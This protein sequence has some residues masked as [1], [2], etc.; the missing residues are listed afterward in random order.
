MSHPGSLNGRTAAFGI[1]L[2][3]TASLIVPIVDG[4]AKLLGESF[5]PLMVAW[6]RYAMAALIVLPIACVTSPKSLLPQTQR[7][8]H[9]MRTLCLVVAMTLFFVSLQWTPLATAI[10]AYFSGPVIA[11]LLS[12]LVLKERINRVKIASLILA[13]VGALIILR[14]LDGGSLGT[15]LAFL[16]GA[17]HAI[18]LIV[19]KVAS[20]QSDSLQTLS[21]QCLVGT[22]ILTPQ[23]V[24]TFTLP[25][26]NLWWLFI[27]MGAISALAHF[28]TIQAFHYSEASSLAPLVYLELIGATIFGALV[29]GGLPDLATIAGGTLIAASGLLLQWTHFTTTRRVSEKV[30]ARDYQ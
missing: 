13:T 23:A 8:A 1:V 12:V 3:A 18:Y 4:I 24:M 27:T 17:F 25:P 14:P 26:V 9:F 6:G 16:T 22:L 19:T 29:F 10:A 20:S 2:M 21:F 5:S 28:L 7:L 15:G 11:M 30:V